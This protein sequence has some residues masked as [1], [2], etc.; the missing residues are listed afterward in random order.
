MSKEKAS[1]FSLSRDSNMMCALLGSV[2][3]TT[4]VHLFLST[5]DPTAWKSHFCNQSQVFG[6]I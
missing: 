1:I 4:L 5:P 6:K 2:V 3:L